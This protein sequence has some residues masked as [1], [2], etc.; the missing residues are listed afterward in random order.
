MMKDL[1]EK[2]RKIVTYTGA[3]LIVLGG[4]LIIAAQ[5][6]NIIG[7]VQTKYRAYQE[8]KEKERAIKE[9]ARQEYL[10]QE[11]IRQAQYEKWLSEVYSV[12]P[13]YD[14]YNYFVNTY[15]CEIQK[16]RKWSTWLSYSGIDTLGELV[17]YIHKRGFNGLDDL[18]GIGR[19]G[20]AEI[21]SFFLAYGR[22][23]FVYENGGI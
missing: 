19:V 2:Q 9:K 18:D 21:I 8:R 17:Y 7:Y 23:S 5:Y 13:I 10:K 3:G 6:R 15:I 11:A 16:F 1:T 20:K 12:W 22:K 14:S 4:T